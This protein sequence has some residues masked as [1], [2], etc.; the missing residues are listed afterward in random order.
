MWLRPGSSGTSA[1]V[2]AVRAFRNL[3]QDGSQSFFSEGMTDEIRGQLSK[4]S[5]L[6]VLSRARSIGLATP[7]APPSHEFGTSHLV[8]GSVR[9]DGGRV[10][11]AVELV[12]AVTQ[13][14][15]WSGIRP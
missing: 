2:V 4:I 14:T 7:M 11:V 5:A 10:R 15:R 12:D 6:R 8:E 13:Q 9:V 1:P 3:S